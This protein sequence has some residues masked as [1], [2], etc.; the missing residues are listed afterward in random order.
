MSD[1]Q[2]NTNG[3]SGPKPLMLKAENLT[4]RYGA[5]VNVSASSA[6]VVG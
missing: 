3:S 4:A 2:D 1:Q 5:V 6:S